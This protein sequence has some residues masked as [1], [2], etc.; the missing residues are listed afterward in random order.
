MLSYRQ[1][2]LSLMLLSPVM[3]ITTAAATADGHSAGDARPFTFWYWMYGAVSKQ[4]IHADLQGMKEVGLGGCYLMPIRGVNEHPDYGGTAQQLTP[5][6]WDMVDYAF[7]QADSLGL[8]M[9][10]HVCDG[11]ALA[12]HPLITPEESM[13]KVVWS[14]TVV[15][16][17]HGGNSVKVVLRQPESYKG[18]YKDIA[19]YAV[20]FEERPEVWKPLRTH[21]SDNISTAKGYMLASTP[22]T[23]THEYASPVTVRS[24]H[25]CPQGNNYQS[26]RLLVEASDDGVTFRPVKQ[27][28]PPR[29][30]WQNTGADYTFSIPATTARWFRFSWTPEGTEGGAEDLD[31]AKWKPLLKLASITLSNMPLLNQWEGK[32]AAVWRID[33]DS[34]ATCQPVAREDIVPLKMNAGGLVS[35]DLP[36]GHWMLL[37]MGHTSTGQMNATAGGGKG[38]EVDKMNRQAVDKLIDGWFLQFLKRPHSSVVKYLHVDSWECA[39]QNWSEHFASEFRERRGYDLLPYMPLFAGIVVE[40]KERSEQVLH[41]VRQTISELTNDIFYN[42]IEE[43]AHIYRCRVSHESIAP[44]YVADALEH[45]KYAD[46]PMGEYWLQSPT[47]DKPNDMLDAVSGAHIYGKNIVQAEGFTEVRGVWN[48]TPAMIKPLL[49]R[50]FALGMNRLFFHVDAHNPWMDRKPGMTLDG[51]GLF[52]QRDNIWYPE[53]TGLVDYVTTCQTLLQKGRPVVDIA[54]FTGEDVPARSFTPDKL[55]ALLPGLVGTAHKHRKGVEESPVGVTHAADILDLKDWTNALHGYKYDSMNRDALLNESRAE[56]GRLVMSGGMEYKVLVVPQQKLSEEV[57]KKIDELRKSGVV[58]IDKPYVEADL[59][60]YGIMPDAVL[61]E[62]MDFAHRYIDKEDI[63]FITNQQDS[64]RDVN[65]TFRSAGNVKINMPAYASAFVVSHDGQTAEVMPMWV[66]GNGA[67]VDSVNLCNSRWQVKFRENDVNMTD[68]RL[69]FDWSKT[70]DIH[71]RYFSGHA[72]FSTTFR[73]KK[74]KDHGRVLL[75]LGGL[76]DVARVIV[77]GKECG[78]AWTEPYMVDVTNALTNG[79]NTLQIVVANTW[80]NALMG[81]DAGQPPYP[82]IWT[83][84]KYRSKDKALLKAGLDSAVLKIYKQTHGGDFYNNSNQ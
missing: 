43:R 48:E 65:V 17:A 36:Q 27:L 84:A 40:S 41:D 60:Q 19:A 45:Y 81:H 70:E 63:Y 56:N 14:D 83:N 46:L 64:A 59:S 44:T 71:T 57:Q 11:F 62:G 34:T 78:I 33:R 22:A 47:H 51:I 31:A 69:P 74:G 4:G 30:G 75:Q 61:P 35:A 50:H 53:A 12:G 42:A 29:Q 32:T 6:F 79:K 80:H 54:V 28:V 77:N 24:I 21:L 3:P 16:V 7:Q 5:P 49:D 39:T 10:I 66:G 82:G 18:W 23:I 76:A 20:R 2:A 67:A 15:S 25:I 72:A 13:Q 68:V 73:Y 9:G 38:L 52:F 1:W 37:R 55:Q 58:I 26:Q 8:E